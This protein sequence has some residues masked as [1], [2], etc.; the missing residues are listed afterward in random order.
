MQLINLCQFRYRTRD[1]HI[2]LTNFREIHTLYLLP[3]KDEEYIVL[4]SESFDVWVEVIGY[5]IKIQITNIR[6]SFSVGFNQV[7][8]LIALQYTKILKLYISQ[9][10][11]KKIVILEG[12]QLGKQLYSSNLIFST[13]ELITQYDYGIY[14]II[15]LIRLKVNLAKPVQAL[16]FQFL[17]SDIIRIL[18]ISGVIIDQ[19]IQEYSEIGVIE[20]QN[21]FDF[22]AAKQQVNILKY[23]GEIKGRT[24]DILDSQTKFNSNIYTILVT[25]SQQQFM[26]GMGDGSILFYKIDQQTLKIYEKPICYHIFAKNPLLSALNCSIRGSTFQTIE[27]ENFEKVLCEKGAKK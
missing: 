9:E 20:D 19:N 12:T 4:W 1:S 26:L 15:T 18:S 27:N 13:E 10:T 21:Q 8:S 22:K 2:Y 16:A 5:L 3:I 17:N 6:F 7:F 25:P 24:Q 14:L 23:I 11:I